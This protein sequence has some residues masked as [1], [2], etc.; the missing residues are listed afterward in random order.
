M[1]DGLAW[2]FILAVI[3]VLA[4]LAPAARLAPSIP[5]SAHWRPKPTS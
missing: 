5:W 4:A 2:G 1:S 3:A